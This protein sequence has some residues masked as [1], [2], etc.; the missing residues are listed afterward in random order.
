MTSFGWDLPAGVSLNDIDDLFSEQEE[1]A[2]GAVIVCGEITLEAQNYLD[3]HGAH[4]E[5]YA[6]LQVVTLPASAHVESCGN[7]D[8]TVSLALDSDTDTR[9]LVVETAL[10]AYDARITYR[11]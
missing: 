10:N 3:S 2:N 5:S 6:G 9:Y 1:E 8:Y 7:G 4:L 11:R